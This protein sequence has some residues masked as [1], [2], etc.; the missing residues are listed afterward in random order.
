MPEP[1]PERFLNDEYIRRLLV[2]WG[3]GDQAA[4]AELAALVEADLRRLASS[5]LA[6]E[7]RSHTLQTTALINEAKLRLLSHAKSVRWQDRQHFIAMTATTM[8]RVLV[9]H[10]RKRNRQLHGGKLEQVTFEKAFELGQ[11]MNVDL[12]ALD[13]ALAK[14]AKRDPRSAQVVEL[15]FFGGLTVRETADA[16]EISEDTVLE[17]W[18]FARTW[19]H[20]KLTT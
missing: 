7:R 2:A 8:R 3:Q 12:V 17:D 10:A 14:L 4:F 6:R 13:E 11:E 18:H 15:R 1:E 9:D 20:S 16:L 5:Y 19:L